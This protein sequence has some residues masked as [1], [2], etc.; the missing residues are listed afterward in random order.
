MNCPNCGKELNPGDKFCIDCGTKI[1]SSTAGDQAGA[2]NGA[3]T[4]NNSYA[5][6]AGNFGA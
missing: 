3:G 4:I 2:G 1:E 5:A 6:G